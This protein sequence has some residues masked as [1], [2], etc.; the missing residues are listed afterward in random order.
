M[1]HA[2]RSLSRHLQIDKS[3]L[4][5]GILSFVQQRGSRR[6][7]GQMGEKMM[8]V[9]LVGQQRLFRESLALVLSRLPDIATVEHTGSPVEAG[10]R[11]APVDIALI[12]ASMPDETLTQLNQAL[13]AL[14]PNVRVVVLTRE[15]PRALPA[16]HLLRRLE[17]VPISARLDELIAVVRGAPGI[18][19]SQ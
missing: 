7:L 18:L 2:Q 16:S 15:N 10:Q 3:C 6:A 4:A 1:I 14:N 17:R 5:Y 19:A 13:M 12:A 11:L 8:R 9:L